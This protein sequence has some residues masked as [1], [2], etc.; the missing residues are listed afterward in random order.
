MEKSFVF[1]REK[2]AKERK[3]FE[4]FLLK[5]PQEHIRYYYRKHLHAIE[6]EGV[7]LEPQDTSIEITKKALRHGFDRAVDIRNVYL[8]AR[9]SEIHPSEDQAEQMKKL[10]TKK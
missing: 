5:T 4:R 2:N 10:C 8:E 9:Y 7:T 1:G 6:N 3:F